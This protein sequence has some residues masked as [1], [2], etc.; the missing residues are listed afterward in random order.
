LRKSLSSATT[1]PAGAAT[2]AQPE[3]VA[4]EG[5]VVADFEG[6]GWPG[7]TVQ[8]NAFGP[9]P[10]R[11]YARLASMDIAAF[12]GDGVA[13]SE[14]DGDGPTGTITHLSSPSGAATSP[15]GSAAAPLTLVRSGDAFHLLLTP[16]VPAGGT[17][18]LQLAEPLRGLEIIVDRTSIEVFANNGEFSYSRCFLPDAGGITLAAAGGAVGVHP[19]TVHP[20]RSLWDK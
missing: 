18:P 3:T 5:I 8:G 9:G 7:W 13:S 1:S 4:S 10:V 19:A 16:D 2:G 20:L 12:H 11:G 6:A 17:G 14:P 15:T